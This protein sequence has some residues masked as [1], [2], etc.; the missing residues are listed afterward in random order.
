MVVF[1]IAGEG[2]NNMRRSK[3]KA[4]GLSSLSDRSKATTSRNRKQKTYHSVAQSTKAAIY[5]VQYEEVCV[6][7]EYTKCFAY[8]RCFSYN[9]Q[10]IRSVTLS[11]NKPDKCTTLRAALPYTSTKCYP[12]NTSRR[13][14]IV[15][16]SS[17]VAIVCTYL[18]PDLGTFLLNENFLFYHKRILIKLFYLI[19]KMFSFFDT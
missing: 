5:R 1:S 16:S 14:S 17:M 2:L 6:P 19:L 7:M 11:R 3:S 9:V 8:K 12:A 18:L 10:L 15:R 4:E 13:P